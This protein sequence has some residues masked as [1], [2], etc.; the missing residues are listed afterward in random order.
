MLIVAA[1][2]PS[3][4]GGY[5]A[6]LDG[7]VS[8]DTVGPD[9]SWWVDRRVGATVLAPGGLV[10]TYAPGFAFYER[11]TFAANAVG[12]TA[13]VLALAWSA[14]PGATA[15]QLVQSLVR[16]TGPEDHELRD[17]GTEVGYGVVD[18]LHL[19]EHDPTEYPDLNPLL[20]TSPDRGPALDP[21]AGASTTATASPAAAA[22]GSAGGSAGASADGTSSP[23]LVAG[24]ALLAAVG[25][26]VAFRRS[27][28]TRAS[29]GP[30]TAAPDRAAPLD[31]RP[32]PGGT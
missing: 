1:Q 29:V 25:V 7:V 14:Y 17:P 19:L 16:N 3:S 6:D 24:L 4:T 2:G 20:T 32:H 18:V 10:R 31:P 26:G 28:H 5:P 12:Y 23:L 22:G 11:S 8:V 9:D 15:N 13:G 30:T 27:P 21:T